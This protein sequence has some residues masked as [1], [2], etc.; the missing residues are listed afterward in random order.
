MSHIAYCWWFPY[1]VIFVQ[2]TGSQSETTQP[3][4]VIARDHNQVF[5]T[6]WFGRVKV[7]GIKSIYYSG[8]LT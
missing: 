4:T 1:L 5:D 8:I 3:V 2:A 7:G 6:T